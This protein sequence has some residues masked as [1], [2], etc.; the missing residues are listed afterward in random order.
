MTEQSD[1][2]LGLRRVLEVA[3]QEVLETGE[4][5]CG[6][7]D[8]GSQSSVIGM[9]V[10]QVHDDRSKDRNGGSNKQPTNRSVPKRSR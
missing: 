5:S 10:L 6:S 4:H 9:E 8:E 2:V 1:S 3:P 7:D